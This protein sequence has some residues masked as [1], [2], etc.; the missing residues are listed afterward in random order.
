MDEPP[1]QPGSRFPQTQ[2][3][4]LVLPAAGRSDAP[5]CREALGRLLCIYQPALRAH[6]IRRRGIGEEAADD[7][8]QGFVADKVL[9]YG[10][11][12][13][14]DRT[15]GRFRTFLLT[16]LDRYVID[17]HHRGASR[18]ERPMEP[19]SL[20]AHGH[21]GPRNSPSPAEAD[22]FEQEWA[23]LTVRCAVERMRCRCQAEARPQ[24]W[25]LFEKRLL[26]PAMTGCE[27]LPYDLLVQRFGFESPQQAFNR[28]VTAK[29]M[30]QRCL[31]EVVAQTTGDDERAI[32]A[33]IED[34]LAILSR[35]G[36]S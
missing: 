25:D 6:L 26:N 21:N 13:R 5:G 10:L 33:E 28:L 20:A 34:L 11:L 17:T 12:A 36:A 30:F 29:R 7:L 35:G 2:W 15:R 27:P 31:R 1:S 8:L 23:R 3:T 9:E 19:A 4:H 14:A 22:I 18:R 16:A 32:E 24:L